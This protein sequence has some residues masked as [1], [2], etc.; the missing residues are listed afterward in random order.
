LEFLTYGQKSFQFAKLP[1]N[2]VK[3]T[4]WWFGTF[5]I[6]PYIGTV[7]IPTDELIFFRGVGIPATRHSKK[8]ALKTNI[9]TPKVRPKLKDIPLGHDN[10]FGQGAVPHQLLTYQ[11]HQ[12]IDIP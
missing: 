1:E 10:F 5:L 7:I 9:E 6:F 2:T 11:L 12:L 4:G 3:T 8:P